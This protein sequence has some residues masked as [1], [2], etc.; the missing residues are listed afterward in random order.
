MAL[1]FVTM[2]ACAP[3]ADQVSQVRMHQQSSA[4]F[5]RVREQCSEHVFGACQEFER[6]LQAQEYYVLY[7]SSV[8]VPGLSTPSFA[9]VGVSVHPVAIGGR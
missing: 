3:A 8:T 5:R 9:P 4:Y 6:A 7:Y 2:A 1:A